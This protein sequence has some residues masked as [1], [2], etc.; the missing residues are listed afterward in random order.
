ME[1]NEFEK[2]ST[3]LNTENSR[4]PT[5]RQ[6][7]RSL[8]S[9][10][11]SFV[12]VDLETTGF[13]PKYNEI[14]EISAIKVENG[15][16]IGTFSELVKPSCPVDSFITRLTG[17]TDD[18]LA[19]CRC[20]SDV[21]PDFISFVGD[22]ILVGHNI[23][24]DVNF[25]YDNLLELSGSIFDNDFVD[26]MRLSK[27]LLP[28]LVNHKLITLAKY[29]DISPT[30]SHRALADCETT[31]L[32]YS[33]LMNEAIEKYGSLDEFY[34][35]IRWARNIEAT[36][37]EIALLEQLT[38][39]DTNPF[40]NKLCTFKGIPQL[41]TYSFINSVM[42]KCNAKFSDVFFKDCD[43]IIFAKYTYE[44]FLH[45]ETSEKFEKA[46][47]LVASGSLTVI[48]EDE[49][50][51]MLAIPIPPVCKSN[52]VKTYEPHTKIHAKD[53]T[54][55]NDSFD[56][57]HPL[58]GKTC[59]FTG[60]L[61][62]MQRKDAMQLVVDLGGLCSDSITKKTNYL[63]L[64]NTDYCSNIKGNKTSKT[65]KAEKAKLDG[66]DIEI[67]S[68]NVFLELVNQ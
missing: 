53:I 18:M 27:R 44:K 9:F 29:Y 60:A 33:H 55:Q 22:S 65:L 39:D 63:I 12:V 17:I 11:N 54:S 8:I 24:F 4:F 16:T 46:K 7:G 47:E 52:K 26:T 68:E 51:K 19:S 21:L 3:I 30:T 20:V 28:D 1:C 45:G 61:E 62:T 57:T 23:N 6:K 58:Y 2:T 32:C 56:E 40:Y 67:I 37:E 14:I 43:Y 35:S 42:E 10:L 38:F 15:E 50:C 66:Q 48:S 13:D 59:C 31:L 36:K 25:I 5:K 41:Y 64:G 34:Y 49:W